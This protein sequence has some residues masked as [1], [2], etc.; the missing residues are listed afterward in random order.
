MKNKEKYYKLDDVGIIG[1]QEKIPAGSWAHHKNK[2][3]EIFKQVRT[4]A[5]SRISPL[6]KF[7]N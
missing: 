1:S 6:K 7:P 3:G 4:A 2:T 5:A